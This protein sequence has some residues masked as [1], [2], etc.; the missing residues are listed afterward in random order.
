M[1]RFGGRA[2]ESTAIAWCMNHGLPP[3]RADSGATSDVATIACFL[4]GDL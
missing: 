4:R 3:I 1:H 2:P